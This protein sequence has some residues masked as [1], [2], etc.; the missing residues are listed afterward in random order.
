MVSSR[1]ERIGER[2]D[3]LVPDREV[4]LLPPDTGLEV[5]V[6]EQDLEEEV[7]DEVGLEALGVKDEKKNRLQ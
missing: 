6:A 1:C 5:V 4:V 3:L 2:D 7:E